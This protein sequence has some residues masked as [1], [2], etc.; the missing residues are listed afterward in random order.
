M[1][2]VVTIDSPIG[3]LSLTVS[4]AAVRELRM[5]TKE[6]PIRGDVGDRIV[7]GDA[8][9]QIEAYFSGLLQTFELPLEPVGTTF[10]CTRPSES[11]EIT[12]VPPP[13]VGVFSAFSG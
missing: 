4:E 11:A 1:P 6:E 12:P 8:V 2:S 5:D 13:V 7:A 9:A 3:P 10:Q